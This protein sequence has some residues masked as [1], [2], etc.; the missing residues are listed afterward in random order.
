MLFLTS[1]LAVKAFICTINPYGICPERKKKHKSQFIVYGLQFI[2]LT[3]DLTN[4]TNIRKKTL[5]FAL[6]R[7]SVDFVYCL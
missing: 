2:F 5:R 7:F 1:K 3:T 4:L 6:A